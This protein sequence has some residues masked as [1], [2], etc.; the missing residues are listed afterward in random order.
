MLALTQGALGEV[1]MTQGNFEEAEPL[2]VRSEE[3][4][5]RSQASEN[6]RVRLARPS[7]GRGR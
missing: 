1:L 7:C 5:R 2:L 4:L 6:E 3:S